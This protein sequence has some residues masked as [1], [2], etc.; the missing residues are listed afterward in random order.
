MS[1]PKVLVDLG[2]EVQERDWRQLNEVVEAVKMESGG[3]LSED[4]FIARLEGYT[5]LIR[6]GGRMPELTQRVFAALPQLRIAGVRGDRFGTGVDLP[7]AA[8]HGVKVVDTDNIG[9]AAPVAEWDLALILVCL[10]NG[11]AVYRQ[12]ME[13]T[14]TWAN[15]QNQDF[16]N[17]ELTGRKVGL[18]GCGHV[19]QRLVE[20]LLP[21]QVDLKVYD[22]YVKEDIVE[23]LQLVRGELDQVLDHADI[24]VVQ[25]PHTPRTEKLIGADELARLGAGRILINC[26]R[27][28]VVDQGALIEVLQ[29][30][31][32][33]AGLDVFD[34]E[35]LEKDSPL[36]QLPNVFISPHIAWHA[37]NALHR[38]FAT[39]AE[40]FMRF[41]RG[42]D[43]H[44]ELTQRMVDIRN[45]RM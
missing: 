26:C 14:E 11:A 8:A 9:S 40:D 24:L 45:G 3:L 6:L 15:A 2:V 16:V 36:R 44:Y 4:E 27:G 10:R 13:G 32:L 18:I 37:P 35:P 7:A 29:Q 43:L 22:P 30:G 19:G 39:M 12:M 17:G 38:Y 34:P 33:I 31:K 23:R 42:E 5:G 28:P 1:R 21:F 20:L 41:F 25:V